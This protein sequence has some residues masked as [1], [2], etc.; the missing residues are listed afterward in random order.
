MSRRE[1]ILVALVAVV[2]GFMVLMYAAN[3][4]MAGYQRRVAE[5][6]ALLV[7]IDDGE[8]KAQRGL[9]MA[10]QLQELADRSVRPG[11]IPS[12]EY[13]A[14]L[15][16]RA[17]RQRGLSDVSVTN[18]TVQPVH[19]A[20]TVPGGG[21]TP[22]SNIAFYLHRFALIGDGDLEQLTDLAFDLHTA[23][24]NHRMSNWTIKPNPNSK[25]FKITMNF[26][27]L[28]MET[29]PA[30][31]QLTLTHRETVA[32]RTRDELKESILG[33]NI[34]GPEN[35][36]P[37][38]QVDSRY[39]AYVN[40]PFS[41][42]LEATDPDELDNVRFEADYEELDRA[43][44][45]ERDGRLDWTPRRTG[46]YRVIVA[47]VDD[48][49]PRGRAEREI[50]IRVENPPA[51][52]VRTAP[53][54]TFPVAKLIYVSGITE[55]AGQK[56][57]WLDVRSE[58]RTLQLGVG[59]EFQLGNFEAAIAAIDDQRVEIESGGRRVSVGLGKNLADSGF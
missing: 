2:G 19:F 53:P 18:G 4:L 17:D 47:A 52:V 43:R 38:L 8:L 31:K 24:I 33:R 46:E 25:T 57:V 12:P 11:N 58:G 21:G 1:R 6:R 49:F 29:A 50:T 41:L 28:A 16:E 48:A 39:V 45:S 5:K 23:D 35:K 9:R 14:W 42:S 7:Q 27:V 22:E 51:R 54:S 59:D 15:M 26:E 10:D 36:P 37:E 55:T 44:F 20:G 13:S 56:Q 32:G 40:Q 3:S 30:R 34:F